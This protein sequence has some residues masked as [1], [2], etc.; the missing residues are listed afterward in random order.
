MSA[1]GPIRFLTIHCTASPTGRGDNA[2]DV[3][4]WDVEKY[5][6]HSYHWV[7]EESGKKVRCLADN[8]KGAHVALKN[9]GN[10]GVAYIGGIDANGHAKDTR[11]AEQRKSLQEIV[12]MYRKDHPG[13]I[14]RGHRDWPGV[15]KDCP[16]FDVAS[17]L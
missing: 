14:V 7:V 16:S 4:R 10:I 11:T 3:C 9:T 12:A 8:E 5:R 6:Q 17:E 1:L 2:S 15:H 13:L